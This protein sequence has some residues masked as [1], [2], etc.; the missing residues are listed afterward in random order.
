[1]SLTTANV[2]RSAPSRPA[3]RTATGHAIW[4]GSINVGAVALLVKLHPAVREKR[5]QFNLL[6]K[7]DLVKLRRQMVCSLDGAQVPPEDQ[8]RGFELEGGRYIIVEPGELEKAEPEA[9]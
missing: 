2:H 7:K 3:G 9:G 8:T 4:N 5:I 1:M 6:H